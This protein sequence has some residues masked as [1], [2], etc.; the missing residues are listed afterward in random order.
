MFDSSA[1]GGNPEVC[2]DNE[3]ARE[4]AGRF[5][6]ELAHRY[7]NHPA[8][9]GYDVWNECNYDEEVCYCPAT[10]RRFREWLLQKYSDVAALG[11]AWGATS[12]SGTT[13]SRPAAATPTATCST[14]WSSGATTHT[15]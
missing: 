7:A 5:L 8:M 9:G 12:A 1:V 2:L 15:C 6:R 13:W 14:G 4:L 11:H 10:A 3:D